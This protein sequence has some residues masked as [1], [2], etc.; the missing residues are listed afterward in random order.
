VCQESG[1]DAIGLWRKFNNLTF[2]QALARLERELGLATPEVPTEGWEPKVDTE[3]ERFQKFYLVCEA[4]LLACKA[5]YRKQGDM[6]GYLNVGSI[7]DRTRYRVDNDIWPADKGV[8][9]LQALLERIHV[10]V[11]AC[12]D[13]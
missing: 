13:G 1:W 3:R 6:H 9:I 8:K 10:K 5:A 2:G 12:L 7:L 11:A 4:R